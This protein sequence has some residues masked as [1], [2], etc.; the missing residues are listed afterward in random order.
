MAEATIDRLEI[1]IEATAS[2]AN[3][4]IKLFA[5]NL[6]RAANAG[7]SSGWSKILGNIRAVSNAIK[8]SSVGKTKSVVDSA[9]R[10]AT[11]QQTGQSAAVKD[12]A[13]LSE[14]LKKVDKAVSDQRRKLGELTQSLYA[15]TFAPKGSASAIL[16]P[17]KDKVAEL[18]T[19]I[20]ET[21]NLLAA[22]ARQRK[23][24]WD[25]FN[26]PI[27]AGQIKKVASVTSTLST[28]MK[29]L[30]ISVGE[31]INK[32]FGK[33]G[34]AVKE[35]GKQ[36]LNNLIGP[37]KRSIA[38]IE[39]WKKSLGRVAYLRAVRS[40]IKLV[41]D[42]FKEGY[43][44]FKA[45]SDAAGNEFSASLKSISANA[46]Y[47]K[48][49]LGALAAPLVNSIAP[50]ID[51]LIDKFVALINVINMLMS[52]L[53]GRG[54]YFR[55]V[56]GAGAATISMGNAMDKV[57]VA[58]V[59]AAKSMNDVGIATMSANNSMSGIALASIETKNAMDGIALA[60]VNANDG[61]AVASNTASEVKDSLSEVGQAAN[62]S[63][64]L[65]KN[66]SGAA[67]SAK[68]IRRYLIGIDELNV[69]PDQGSGGGGGGGG[70]GGVDVSGM[71][72]EVPLPDW[73]QGIKDAIDAGQWYEAGELLA[74]KVNE[75]I[76]KIDG[77]AWGRK[78]GEKIQDGIEFALGFL[79][80]V[81]WEQLGGEAAGFLNGLVD[82]INPEDLGALLAQKVQIAVELAYGFINEFEWDEFGDWLGGVV[83]G[84]FEEIEWD[85]LGETVSDG[86]EGLLESISHFLEKTDWVKVGEDIGTA[87][88]AIDWSGIWEGLKTALE[89][90]VNAMTGIAGGLTSEIGGWGDLLIGIGTAFA[91]WKI[92]NNVLGWFEKLSSGAF[93]KQLQS[94]GTS[95]FRVT[96]GLAIAITGYTL[97]FASVRDIVL[98]G[99]N[100]K[101][102]LKG[103]LT[104]ALGIAGT[105]LVFGTGPLGW[106]VSISLAVIIGLSALIEA[107]YEKRQLEFESS[108]LGQKVKKWKEDAAR[109]EDVT[110][111]INLKLETSMQD[112]QTAASDIEAIK[113]M[114]E[115]AFALDEI[116][117]KTDAQQAKLQ[118]LIDTINTSG[119]ENVHLDL[120][121]DGKIVQT[122]DSLLEVTDALIKQAQAE[123]AMEGYRKAYQAQVEA[124]ANIAMIRQ[125]IADT[126]A[127]VT[128]KTQELAVAQEELNTRQN[129]GW[130]DEHLKPYLEAVDNAKLGLEGAKDAQ[131]D[132]NAQL[133]GA[134]TTLSTANAYA[135]VYVD[136]I[137][138]LKQASSEAAT[139]QT[140][141][142][143]AT[144]GA[145]EALSSATEGVD[146]YKD[147]VSGIS[148]SMSGVSDSASEMQKTVSDATAGVTGDFSD[149]SSNVTGDNSTM[150]SDSSTQWE[151]IKQAVSD[152][153]LYVQT[154]VAAVWNGAQLMTKLANQAMADEVKKQWAAI[155]SNVVSANNSIKS[156][157]TSS[158]NSIKNTVTTALNTMNTSVQSATNTMKSN[159][160]SA[161]SSINSSASSGWSTI[162]GTITGAASG[163]ASSVSYSLGSLKNSAYSWGAD[164]CVNMASG[165]NNN[166][167]RV[168]SAAS[169]LAQAVKDR[170]GFSE[171][172]L[173]PLSDFHTY[174][175][176]ML[177]MMA[178]GIRDN[179]GIAVAAATDLAQSISE[180]FTEAQYAMSF[181]DFDFDGE[182]E[183]S[184]TGDSDYSG[185]GYDEYVD[186]TIDD[187]SIRQSNEEVINALYAM[188][189]RI[190]E[191]INN[192]DANIVLDGQRLGASVTRVQNMQNRAAGRSLSNA[193][194]GV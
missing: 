142:K 68:E 157:V 128:Q 104:T 3:N 112:Y 174:M 72:E 48:N 37:I 180:A 10:K 138:E 79:R 178:Q 90:A 194:G 111:T 12:A 169:N 78:L 117:V 114:I 41:T 164:I 189:Q 28:V 115:D 8:T 67:D 39:K 11:T 101:D 40:A 132:W 147:S 98:N 51:Y 119:I 52:L 20:Y 144:A 91:S 133:E 89:D 62:S 35:L 172:K 170:V 33:L 96:A 60:S 118:A 102:V 123:A 92:S 31:G 136:K 86:V 162:S 85:K 81:H 146:A 100:L 135:D 152:A 50:A 158:W 191:A 173:G 27:D 24:L 107:S 125:G 184:M 175:P 143:D 106:T 70:A 121:P 97:E 66:L 25:G 99:P 13:K 4:Q 127:L 103:V 17:D 154:T 7:N 21:E 29:N 137:A 45:F 65:G 161:W 131:A 75:L 69:I 87:I 188:G 151:A 49:S 190:I 177:K 9:I 53:S 30:S 176:D 166:A 193:Y 139:A 47:L 159:L 80:N 113:Q 155:R 82:T 43:E 145:S 63:G 150:S 185:S 160:S 57:K 55:A 163:I 165:I 130:D 59:S 93:S 167:Y 76:D 179:A 183:Y 32:A 171:P 148:E 88:E 5:E 108:E 1:E 19:E 6:E 168:K 149:M 46:L 73:A 187:S 156:N 15:E 129:M 141:I 44:N 94:M 84:W 71:F 23:Q 153:A 38:A 74:D 64:E 56:R 18:K 124:E 110:K 61:I 22:L 58:S 182:Y 122:R 14:A 109:A 42:G 2:S 26:E 36:F 181:D 120:D 105:L 83:N 16:G 140:E 186:V 126:T 77:E 116:E 54:T 95:L 134:E 192:K 34:S